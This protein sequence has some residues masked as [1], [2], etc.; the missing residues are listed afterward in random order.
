[1]DCHSNIILHNK[2]EEVEHTH[3]RVLCIAIFTNKYNLGIIITVGFL[4]EKIQ[5]ALEIWNTHF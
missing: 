4:P 5:Y 2:N 1:M 3:Y